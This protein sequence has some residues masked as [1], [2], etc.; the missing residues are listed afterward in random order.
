MARTVTDLTKLLDVMAGYDPDDPVTAHGVGQIRHGFTAFLD[1][2]S[3]P[4]A[5]ALEYCAS[6]WAMTPSQ[7][8][9]D[10]NKIS[11]VFDKA[12]ADLE[13]LARNCRPVEIPDLK[14]LLATSRQLHR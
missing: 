2:Q 11:E 3:P 10:F 6:R 13:P 7:V 8:L 4:T 5:R 14:V 1:Q 12:V 9:E